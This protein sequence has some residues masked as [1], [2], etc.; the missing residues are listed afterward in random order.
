MAIGMVN[1][2]IL[3]VVWTPRGTARRIISARRASRKERRRYYA[4]RSQEA[5]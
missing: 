5:H 2:I 4:H 3:T 1:G